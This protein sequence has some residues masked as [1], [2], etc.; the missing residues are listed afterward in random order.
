MSGQLQMMELN[1]DIY[2]VVVHGQRESNSNLS[3]R[4]CMKLFNKTL[5]IYKI[6][7]EKTIV[8]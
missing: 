1:T 5:C 4:E 6:E 2:L 8:N 7:Y 3:P